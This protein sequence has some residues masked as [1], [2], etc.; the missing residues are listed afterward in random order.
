MHEAYGVEPVKIGVGGSIPFIADLV[1]E[2]PG[3]QILV[4]GV[5]DPHARAHSPNESLHLETFRNAVLAEA[6]LLEKLDARTGYGALFQAAGRRIDSYPP[7]SRPVRR[8]AMTDTALSTDQ[9]VRAHGVA[10]TDAAALKV[11]SLL[12]QEGRDDL[13]LRVAVQP[14]GCSGLIYQLYFD[15]RYLDGDKTVDFDGVEVIVDDM[16]VPYLDGAHDRLQGHDLRAGIHHRQP[17]RGRQLR[18][19]RQLPLIRT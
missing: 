1:R 8:S 15:E 4:T 11:R 14:G 5:E 9:T 17:Q 2:F 6:L 7:R 12:A 16:S 13:R 3:A 10:L 18:V 19:R